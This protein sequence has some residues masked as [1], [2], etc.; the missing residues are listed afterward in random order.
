MT[1]S[2]SKS[3]PAE[4]GEPLY[5]RHVDRLR[6]AIASGCEGAVE[7]IDRRPGTKRP[8]PFDR[9]RGALP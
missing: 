9:S 3:G 5:S 7:G 2:I 6:A 4:L 8:R 1:R